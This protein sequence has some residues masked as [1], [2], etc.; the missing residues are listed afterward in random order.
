[1]RAVVTGAAGFI[2]STLAEALLADGHTVDGID[3]FTTYYSPARKRRNVEAILPQDRFHLHEIDVREATLEPLFHDVDT[4]F[5][6]A[7]QPGVR[8]S[9]SEGFRLYDEHNVLGTQR[10]LEAAKASNVAR[11][12]YASSSSVY[13]NAPAF[14][15]T[16][17]EPTRPHSPYGVTKLAGEHLCRLY[18][19]NWGLSTVCLR[20]FTVYGPRQRPDMAMH[21]LIAAGLSGQEF[22]L[23]GSGDQIRDFTFAGDVVAATI[24]AATAGVAPGTVLNVAGGSATRLADLVDLVGELVGNEV[25]VVRHPPQPGDVDRTGGSTERAL[26]CL[27]WSPAT[28]LRA[29]L[30]AQVRWHVAERDRGVPADGSWGS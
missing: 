3:C 13:G 20:Y 16:E 14:P 30:E 11:V 27:D 12:V 15:T 23:Y 25:R 9:W 19:D 4:V 26:A 21:R 24:A 2:G 1:M 17:S 5:H 22:P 8:L 29:G 18:A 7:A 28:G 10:V 6:L